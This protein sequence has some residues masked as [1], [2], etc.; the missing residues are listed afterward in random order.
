MSG[1][2]DERSSGARANV[3]A[4]ERYLYS[5]SASAFVGSGGKRQT[6]AAMGA[7]AGMAWLI[8]GRYDTIA[9]AISSMI[10]DVSGM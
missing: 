9:M 7:A 2:D 3:I 1:A 10:G 8:D 6:T 5:P 4:F